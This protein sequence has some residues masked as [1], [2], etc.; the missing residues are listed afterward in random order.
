VTEPRYRIRIYLLAALVLAGFGVLLLRLHDFQIVRRDEFLRLVPGSRTVAVR[1]PGVR[2][3]ITD[4]GGLVLARNRRTYEVT[5][6][7]AEIHDAYRRQHEA[8]PTLQTV[9]TADGMPRPREEEDIVAIVNRSVIPRL[10]GHGL[11]RNYNAGALRTHF[12]THGGLVPFTYHAGIDY[13][14]FARFA[15]HSLELPCVYVGSTPLREYP[16]GSL[17]GH[18]IGYL[19]KWEKRDI[20]EDARRQFDHY[21]GDDAGVAGVEAS[22]DRYLRGIAGVRK[23]IKDEKGRV[24]GMDD[25]VRPE[26]G[27]RVELSI[28]ARKQYLVENVLRRTGRA[29]AVVLDVNTGEI[30]AMASVPDYDPNKF[31]PSISEADYNAYLRN[32]T[33]PLVNRAIAGLTP[34]STYKLP[35]ALTGAMHGLAGNRYSCTGY[36]P[37]GKHKIGCWIYNQFGG[38]HGGLDLSEAI[39]KSCNPYFNKMANALG[40][41]RMTDG[42]QLLGFGLQT[43]VELPGEDPG[44]LPGNRIWRTSIRPGASM[45]PALTAMLSI[46]QGDAS[47]TP[48]QVAAMVAAIANGGRYYKPRLVRKVTHPLRGTLIE[49]E[50]ILKV[51]L[52]KEGNIRPADLERIRKGMWLAVNK[53]GGTARSAKLPD[54]E[55]AA[56]TGT[57]QTSDRGKKSHNSWT[58]AF[59]PYDEP[60]YAIAVVV[61]GGKSGGKV[62]SPLVHL[63]LRGLFA[64]DDGGLRLPL[65]RMSEFAGN[66]ETI[67]EIELPEDPLAAVSGE[68]PAEELADA[69]ETGD[70]AA[71]AEPAPPVAAPEA[72]VPAPQPTI[73]PEVDAEGSVIP[74][75]IPVQEP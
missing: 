43:G 9:A 57:A 32:P 15:E 53:P 24:V 35:T 19:K 18:L 28:D 49:D 41:T 23:M 4:R 45:T 33:A 72:A 74:R 14:Q 42:F 46:G 58:V 71:E 38:A 65:A 40:S 5:F 54:V 8:E 69:G 2:G 62:A 6:N 31:T 25:Y 67:E 7:L 47:A 34:G 29:A 52:L 36:V 70:E 59:A 75:A 17:G 64:A 51:D 60:R 44:I 21:T 12:L 61:Q 56:K 48:L 39:Q 13:D 66:T 37:Y 11:A 50:P 30:V 16:Y 10:K 55:V 20:P 26:P 22:M 63:I 68:E 1:E 73:T 3:E 27:A